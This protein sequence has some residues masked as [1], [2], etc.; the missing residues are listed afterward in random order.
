MPQFQQKSIQ[1]QQVQKPGQRDPQHS[2]SG[3]FNSQMSE[4]D[5]AKN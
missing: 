4:T 5:M 1:S 2:Q 3:T